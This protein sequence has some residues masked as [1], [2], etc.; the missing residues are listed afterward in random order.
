MDRTHDL[1]IRGGTVAD[2]RGTALFE[3]DIAVDA[4]RITAV[5]RVAGSCREEID[6]RGLL[7]APGFV[8]IHSH[9]DAQAIWDERLLP[10]GWQGVTTTVM[11]NCGVGFAPVRESDRETLIEL[12]EG[13]EDIPGPVL[14]EGLTWEWSSFPEYLDALERRRHDMDVC[15]QL[16]HSALRVFVM[17]ERA[18]RREPATE[19]DIAAMR[20]L[21]RE[22]IEAGA[23]GFTT[24]L[25]DNHRTPQGDFIPS[26]GAQAG[27]LAG[28]ACGLKD[29]GRGVLQIILNLGPDPAERER[30]FAIVR[31]M[32]EASGRPLSLTVLQ[33][34]RDPEGWRH[35]MGMMEAAVRDGLP[36]YAQV[37]PRPL[38]TLFGLDMARHPFCYHPSF[39][40][41][42]DQPL[43]TKVAAFRDPDFRKRLLAEEAENKDESLIRRVQNFDYMFPLGDPP[44]Y[45]PARESSVGYMARGRELS[46]FEVAYDVMLADDGCN[47]LFSPNSG[48]GHFNLEG[49]RELMENPRSVVAV[50]DGGAHVAQI[51]DTSFST[52]LLTYWG[53][54]RGN[55]RLDVSWLIKR[56]TG[57]TAA[58]VGLDD[59]GRIAPGYKAD[60]NVIDFD[61]LRIERPY[62][63][64][65]LPLG[66]KRLL[67]RTRG[68]VST[69]VSGI[70]VYHDGE[71]TGALPGRLV[72]GPQKV[73][74]A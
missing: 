57:D 67:Q 17:G 23:M 64:H 4:G 30:E 68:Y 18:V 8:D 59:R 66:G 29:A 54:D 71:A 24:S 41:I 70:E 1:V 58:L 13:V 32:V 51:C 56:M 11:G 42:A 9:Y 60:I 39:K 2:G 40:A 14:R 31:G 49:C 46:P 12:M 22:A 35:T 3:A 63:V 33:R 47:M 16:P 44:N 19:E 26:R 10:S 38:G 65:D 5:G 72:R 28:V 62:M 27:E 53:R 73:A 25:S 15:A 21:A 34:I 7:V 20:A 61:N 43:E 52:F 36:M 48:Y 50:S 6:A 55:R 37:I 69:I 45:A 74:V